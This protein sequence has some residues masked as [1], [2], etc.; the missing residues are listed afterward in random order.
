MNLFNIVN[1]NSLNPSDINAKRYIDR[2]YNS[3]IYRCH[4][5]YLNNVNSNSWQY[6]YAQNLNQL[7][8]ASATPSWMETDDLQFFYL[9]RK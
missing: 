7:K 5:I 9:K 1:I 6:V 4:A 2:A 8:M 3:R